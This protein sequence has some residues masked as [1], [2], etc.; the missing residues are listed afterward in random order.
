[1]LLGVGEASEG[2]SKWGVKPPETAEEGSGA[3][4]PYPDTSFQPVQVAL[5]RT[6]FDDASA[7]RTGRRKSLQTVWIIG[8][9]DSADR[10]RGKAGES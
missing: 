5:R 3:Y 6:A 8:D 4:N 1:M 10:A 9:G 7:T 2:G